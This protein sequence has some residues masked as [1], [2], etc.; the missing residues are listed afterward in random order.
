ME[1]GPISTVIVPRARDLGDFEVRFA[2]GGE[3]DD[4][5]VH[6]FRPDGAG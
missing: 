3:T 1:A 2:L 5:A 4:W 6:F